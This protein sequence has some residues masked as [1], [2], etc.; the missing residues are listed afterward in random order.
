ML[1]SLTT[2]P[3]SVKQTI[4]LMLDVVLAPVSLLLAIA[5]ASEG[6]DTAALL[7]D[8]W[9]AFA[10][11]TVAAGVLS[12][13]F[14]LHKVQLKSYEISALG[15]SA[16]LGSVLAG[17]LAVLL[18]TGQSSVEFGTPVNL[19]AFYLVLS[20]AV[21]LILLQI[22]IAIYRHNV[23]ETRVLIY[24]AGKTGVQLAMALKSSE[25]IRVV[26]FVD[27]NAVLHGMTVAGL[28]VFPGKRIETLITAEGIGRVLLAMPS[29]S[30]PRL[31]QLARRIARMNVEVQNLPSFAQLI[32]EE[33]IVD[34]LAPVLPRNVLGR[35]HLDAS[36]S[37]GCSAYQGRV[38]MVSGAGGSIGSE[39]CRQ[40]LNCKPAKL[41]LLE[42]TEFTLFQIDREL[43]ALAEDTPCEIV[44][45]LGSVTDAE[46]VATAITE[47]GVQVILHAAAYKHV[48]MVELNPVAGI[49]NNLFGTLTLAQAALDHGIERFV[50]VSTDKAV[51]PLGIMGASKR[52]S[53]IVVGDL[54]RRSTRTIF[55]MVRFGN[56]LGS[57][58]SVV[59]IFQEQISRGGPVTVTDSEVTRYFMTIQEACRLVL[60]AGTL[61]R[62]GE[63]FV[64][65]MGTPI[66]IADLARQVVAA[67]GYTVRDAA[68]PDGDIEIITTG[69]RI[70]E[71]LHE[72]LSINPRM[73]PTS[74]PK[75][76]CAREQFLSEFEIARAL[77]ALR[78]AVDR[79][80]R[81]K[82]VDESLHW[83]Q[84]D[85]ENNLSQMSRSE[86]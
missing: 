67:A 9:P 44:P 31:A 36:L 79:N 45:I 29:L 13:V 86:A 41:V 42:L 49:R 65:D 64:L 19:A 62:G 51:R 82:L 55:S 72:E 78:V 3:R 73:E 38:V 71:K 6:L 50:L 66:R 15:R 34:K 20:A 16:A 37:G 12:V 83:V 1:Q 74:H 46:T 57:S 47:H 7:R 54:A 32:G 33:E 25:E 4:L 28:S 17:L 48:P 70:G 52:L 53:E 22:L 80:D 56:V 76:F 10:L 75:L 60:W 23:P 58:G 27:D 81:Q 39:L 85:L 43:T 26:G 21:R 14:K 18:M 68:N 8:E 69:L 40:I 63:I 77:Q 35:A 61:A 11:L 5:V 59:P 84:R 2:L 30:P 24:G